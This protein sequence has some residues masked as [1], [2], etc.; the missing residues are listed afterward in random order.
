MI[1]GAV[2]RG[3][4]SGELRRLD[5]DCVP[6]L[7]IAPLVLMAVWRHSFDYCNGHRLE[8]DRYIEHHTQILLNGLVAVGRGS[9]QRAA[10]DPQR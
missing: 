2:Q 10:N 1:E 4:D 6:R 9:P 7:V 3:M 8:P 5:P